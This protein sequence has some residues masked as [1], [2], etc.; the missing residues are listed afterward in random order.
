MLFSFGFSLLLEFKY[1]FPF[2]YLIRLYSYLFFVTVVLSCVQLF[3][4]QEL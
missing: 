2:C 4:T 1:N 3:V